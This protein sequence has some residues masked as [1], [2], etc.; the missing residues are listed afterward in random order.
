MG[1]SLYQAAFLLH[2]Q[3]KCGVNFQRTLTIG[4]QSLFLEADDTPALFH[5][6]SLKIT[7]EQAGDM[8]AEGKGYS[9]PFLCRL[10]AAVTDSLDA[11][12]YEGASIIHDMNTPV[13]ESLLHSYTAVIDSGTL[14]HIFDF[15]SAVRNCMDMVSLGGH[16]IA[17]T[18]TNNFNGHGFY[19]FSPELFFRILSKEN[20]FQDTHVLICED[21]SPFRWYEVADPEQIQK[22]VELINHRPAS[23]LVCSRRSELKSPFILR[24]YQSDYVAAWRNNTG[25]GYNARRAVNRPLL[26]LILH[27]LARQ[28]FEMFNVVRSLCHIAT[29]SR[30][31]PKPSFTPVTVSLQ[32]KVSQESIGWPV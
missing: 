4:R 11:S 15:P 24:P 16:F 9:E 27:R 31:F 20:G 13:P 26:R 32:T 7:R 22:R 30:R 18:P 1:I 23:L 12:S 8:V 10:G 19:Q 25:I 21:A 29:T 5:R 6:F 28:P 17:I 14:E 2:L 3:T